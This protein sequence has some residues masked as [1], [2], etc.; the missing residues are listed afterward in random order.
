METWDRFSQWNQYWNFTD[1][2]CPQQSVMEILL[3]NYLGHQSEMKVKFYCQG[4]LKTNWSFSIGSRKFHFLE[5]LQVKKIIFTFTYLTYDQFI[6][7]PANPPLNIV[8]QPQ[9]TS[10]HIFLSIYCNGLKANLCE[11]LKIGTWEKMEIGMNVW[12]MFV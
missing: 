9:S 3:G 12:T 5:V 2:W 8:T 6:K 1:L 11:F 4:H 10:F 7:N